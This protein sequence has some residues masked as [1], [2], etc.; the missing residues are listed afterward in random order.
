MVMNSMPPPTICCVR[1]FHAFDLPPPRVSALRV[2]EL[3]ERGVN[4][5]R[6]MAI[7][8]VCNLTWFLN[9]EEGKEESIYPFEANCT[10]S[11]KE[12]SSNPYPS[13]IKEIQTEERKYVRE[14]FFNPKI[15]EIVKQQ[16]AETMERFSG[17]GGSDW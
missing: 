10:P 14:R 9:K 17:H 8:D 6:A 12:T 2:L 4:E 7:A 15:L 13:A 5:E 16:K 11:R 3:K 1:E